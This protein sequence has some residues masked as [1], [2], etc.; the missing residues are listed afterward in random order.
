M[1]DDDDD[2][3]WSDT[4]IDVPLQ[5]RTAI[6]IGDNGDLVIRQNAI[7]ENAAAP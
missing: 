7:G 5:E 3:R 2:F 1:D 4:D 6:Y